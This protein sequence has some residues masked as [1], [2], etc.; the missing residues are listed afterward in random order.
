MAKDITGQKFGRLTAIKCI[1]SN[2]HKQRVWE[3][4]CDC[5]KTTNVYTALLLSENTRSCGCLHD[6][7]A[8]QR[9]GIHR[10][11]GSKLNKTWKNMKQRCYNPKN[12]KYHNY[13]GKGISICDEWLNSFDCFQKWAFDNGYKEGLTIERKDPN[14]NYEP[15]NCEWIPFKEQH[16]NKSNAVKI[17]IDGKEHYV[18][19]LAIEYGI[20]YETLWRRVKDGW[21]LSILFKPSE[22]GF[23]R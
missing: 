11:T 2:K 23:K 16:I 19:D 13:G 1:G 8:S 17:I 9:F 10:L 20:P 22:F 3:C 18:R 7:M 6:E 12:K 21:D 4:L 14:G 15:S 5:G